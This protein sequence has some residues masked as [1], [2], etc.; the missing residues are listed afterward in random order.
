V[1]SLYR[2]VNTILE[3]TDRNE[4]PVS[5]LYRGVKHTAIKNKS[6]QSGEGIYRGIN[7]VA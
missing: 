7:W 1:G 6:T 2:G 3:N 4:S 5:V